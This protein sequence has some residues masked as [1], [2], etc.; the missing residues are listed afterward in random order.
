MLKDSIQDSQAILPLD[1][2]SSMENIA[3]GRIWTIQGNPLLKG[4]VSLLQENSVEE[5]M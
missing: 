1:K 4:L 5:S 2:T 3:L